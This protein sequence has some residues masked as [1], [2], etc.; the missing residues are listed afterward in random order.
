MNQL[1]I[2]AIAHGDQANLTLAVNKRT[3]ITKE[4]PL[5][6]VIIGHSLHLLT[7]TTGTLVPSPIARDLKTWSWDV[8]VLN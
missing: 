1:R 7:C 4:T 5:M 8:E 6:V 3:A 2:H